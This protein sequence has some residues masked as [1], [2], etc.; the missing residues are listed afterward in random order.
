MSCKYHINDQWK[1]NIDEWTSLNKNAQL[2]KSI[3][4]YQWKAIWINFICG[5]KLYVHEWSSSMNAKNLHEV[6]M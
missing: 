2:I 6:F 5:W 4:N 3:H 1:M